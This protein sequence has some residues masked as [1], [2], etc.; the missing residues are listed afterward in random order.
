[1]DTARQILRFS[2]PGSIAVA[3]SVLL[4][5]VVAVILGSATANELLNSLAQN[6][7]A[8]IAVAAAIP[9]GFVLYQIYYL[10]YRG[11]VWMLFLRPFVSVDKRWVR[12]DRGGE[13]LN[14]MKDR[15]LRQAAELFEVKLDSSYELRKYPTLETIDVTVP[16]TSWLG[17]VSGV[18]VLR[19][20]YWDWVADPSY[21]PRVANSGESRQMV[22]S[23]E[24]QPTDEA[25][26]DGPKADYIFG[27]EGTDGSP[28]ETTRAEAVKNMPKKRRSEMAG[29]KDNP[30]AFRLLEAHDN[31]IYAERDAKLKIPRDANKKKRLKIEAERV[32]REYDGR[33]QRNWAVMRSLIEVASMK[34]EGKPMRSEYTLLSDIYHAL[35]ACRTAVELSWVLSLGVLLACASFGQIASDQQLLRIA[36]AIAVPLVAAFALFALFHK[37]RR[38]TWNSAQLS[39]EMSLNAIFR[40]YPDLLV[41]GVAEN[42]KL[43]GNSEPR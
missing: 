41:R 34:D 21:R 14:I 25:R 36:G 8:L 37:T 4:G 40:K 38:A 29:L 1:M 31:F 18:R 32:Y 9:L 12:K 17:K 7:S 23:V 3:L 42:K 19:R 2:I 20:E 27:D 15:E 43:G 22:G 13:I 35:G 26:A 24:E 33:W 10:T 39:L 5:G 6:V 28:S 16:H 11:Y 30:L